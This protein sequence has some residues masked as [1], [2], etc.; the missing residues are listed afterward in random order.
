MTFSVTSTRCSKAGHREF[1][2]CGESPSLKQDADWL[3]DY[4]ES[5]VLNGVN[6]EVGQRIQIGWMINRIEEG[7]EGLLRIAEPDFKHQPIVFVASVTKTLFHLR[8]Q[9]DTADSLAMLDQLTLP[10]VR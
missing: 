7:D 4:L 9:K 8:I 6:Y 2:L 3:I 5:S 1:R 10:N